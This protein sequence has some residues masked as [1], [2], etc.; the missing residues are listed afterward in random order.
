ML[1]TQNTF[2]SR[3]QTYLASMPNLAFTGLSE[4]WLLKECG[5][6]HWLAL[7]ELHD[8]PLPDFRDDTGRIAYAAFTAVRCWD[9]ALPSVAENRCF[10]IGTRIIRSGMARHFSE[11]TV[12]L[13][14]NVVARVALLST[15]VSRH[16]AGDNRSVTKACLANSNAALSSAS[17]MQENLQ[18]DNRRLRAGDWKIHHRLRREECVLAGTFDFMP[19]PDADYNGAGFLYFANFQAIVDRAEWAL[20]GLRRAGHTVARELH[21]YANL[22]IGESLQV[23]LQTRSPSDRSTHWCE[24]YRRSDNTRVADI[25]TA[26]AYPSDCTRP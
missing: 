21:Y 9:M 6:Q 23:K 24:I 16:L 8:R 3:E 17:P 14:N 25:F 18:N 12:T 20:L 4:N 5:H 1:D 11:H 7:A 13:G 2:A 26:K 15:F 22:N 10:Q 19:C